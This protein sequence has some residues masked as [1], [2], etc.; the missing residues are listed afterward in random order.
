MRRAR[1]ASSVVAPSSATATTA[2]AG[3][4]AAESRHVLRGRALLPL[5]DVELHA[6]ALVE[7]L[8]APALDGGVVDEQVLA[9]V[10]GRDEAEALVVVEP[11]DG[12]LRAHCA[13]LRAGRGVLWRGGAA[14]SAGA[15][16]PSA[17]IPAQAGRSRA[18]SEPKV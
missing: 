5:H 9:S 16:A 17:E 4:P 13:G 8:E 1:S 3:G 11:L 15:A 12:A 7:R 2:A 14:A 10:L 18:G 6:L